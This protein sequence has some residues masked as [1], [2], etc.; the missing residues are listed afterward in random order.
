MRTVQLTFGFAIEAASDDI[1][2]NTAALFAESVCTVSG[3]EFNGTCA[4]SVANFS[5]KVDLS[6]TGCSLS[7]GAGI[8]WRSSSA[9][10]EGYVHQYFVDS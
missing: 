5:S 2:P 4:L 6:R 3:G 8:V 7:T 1:F 10:S 9:G